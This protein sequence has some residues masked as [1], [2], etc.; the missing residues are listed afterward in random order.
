MN[1]ISFNFNLSEEE[2]PKDQK[3]K[4]NLNYSTK[5]SENLERHQSYENNL[6]IVIG[7]TSEDHC[8]NHFRM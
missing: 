6:E 8:H 7:R 5:F 4:D 3:P 1:F 2:K